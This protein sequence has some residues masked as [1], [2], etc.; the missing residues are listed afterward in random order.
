VLVLRIESAIGRHFEKAI[1]ARSSPGLL[2]IQQFIHLPHDLEGIGHVEDIGLAAG[3]ATVGV[4]VDGAAL[5]S[6]LEVSL[7]G[8]SAEHFVLAEGFQG[9]GGN[10][11]DGDGVANGVEDLDGIPLCA[12]R[13]NVVVHQLDDVPAA[14]TMLQKITRQRCISVKLKSHDVLRLSG[15]SVTNFVLPDKC[16][17]IQKEGR[18]VTARLRHKQ[19]TGELVQGDDCVRWQFHRNEGSR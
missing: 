14:E 16:S 8:T 18:L 6:A 7:Q 2:L 19:I 9:G 13:R 3:P 5:A 15:M 1:L 11:S 4:E 12:V 10:G 17:V